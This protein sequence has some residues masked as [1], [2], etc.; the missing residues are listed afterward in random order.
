[1][2]RRRCMPTWARSSAAARWSLSIRSAP[3]PGAG[4]APDAPFPAA[5]AM[6]AQGAAD[7]LRYVAWFHELDAWTE[8]W[9]V[10]HPETKGRFYFGDGQTEEG[11]LGRFLPRT[12]YPPPW[13]AWTRVA[14]GAA[15]PEDFRAEVRKPEVAAAVM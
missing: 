13:T 14:L 6:T 5:P 2:S 4:T 11:L 12:T 9:D 1:M 7:D 3:E 15:Q 10:Y 8:Y